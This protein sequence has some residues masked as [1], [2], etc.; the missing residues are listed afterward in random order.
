[1]KVRYRTRDILTA[2]YQFILFDANVWLYVLCPLGSYSQSVVNSYTRVFKEI[3]KSKKIVVDIVILSEVVNRW[4]KLGF[5]LYKQELNRF[6]LDY[7]RDYR[8]TTEYSTLFADIGKIITPVLHRS[9]YS[10][11]DYTGTTIQRLFQGQ[12]DPLDMNDRHIIE[13]CKS[14]NYCLLTHDADFVDADIPIISENA[15]LIN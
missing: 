5:A 7:K 11:C 3:L 10:T 6:D 8:N 12:Y 9:I 2:P 4:L 1:M 13:I 14:N 15:K